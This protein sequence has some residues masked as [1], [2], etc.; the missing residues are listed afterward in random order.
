M[1]IEKQFGSQNPAAKRFE[2]RLIKQYHQSQN[3]ALRRFP[4][5]VYSF[6]RFWL[7]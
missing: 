3:F 2:R 6:A 7:I 4:Q 1:Y 5:P